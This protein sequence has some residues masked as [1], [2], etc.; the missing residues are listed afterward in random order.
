MDHLLLHCSVAAELW[1]IVF[2]MFGVDWVM[3]K[4]VLDQLA[5]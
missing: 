2:K 3:S 1:G 5:G 4:C